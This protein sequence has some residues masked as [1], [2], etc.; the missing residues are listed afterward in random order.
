MKQSAAIWLYNETIA[1][2]IGGEDGIEMQLSPFGGAAIGAEAPT[3]V[4]LGDHGNFQKE[5]FLAA[6]FLRH[7]ADAIEGKES[8]A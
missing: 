3:V 7:W 5:R 1:H 2:A 4:R 6:K 8:T